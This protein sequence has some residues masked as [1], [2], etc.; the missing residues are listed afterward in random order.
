MFLFEEKIM[1]LSSFGFFQV[2]FYGLIE[3]WRRWW[4]RWREV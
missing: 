3:D 4:R 2:F 1:F